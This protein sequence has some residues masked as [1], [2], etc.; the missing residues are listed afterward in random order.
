MTG[1]IYEIGRY[2]ENR[3][4]EKNNRQR[5]EEQRD[6]HKVE[7]LEEIAIALSRPHREGA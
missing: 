2:F 6:L 5:G 7:A 1:L 4:A 3:R